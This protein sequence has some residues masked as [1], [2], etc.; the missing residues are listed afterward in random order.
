MYD[1][2]PDEIYEIEV[3]INYIFSEGK[4][5]PNYP[6]PTSLTTMR[7]EMESFDRTMGLLS[8]GDSNKYNYT[9]KDAAFE[10]I[11]MDDNLIPYYYS[12]E[13]FLAELERLTNKEHRNFFEGL[14]KM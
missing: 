9:I 3:P 7:Y 5:I 4:Y 8:E 6:S 12:T 11:L 1:V 13:T 10:L 2:G 14:L